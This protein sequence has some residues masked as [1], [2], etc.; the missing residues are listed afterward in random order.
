MPSSTTPRAACCVST[1]ARAKRRMAAPHCWSELFHW[2]G[3]ELFN[4]IDGLRAILSVAMGLGWTVMGG[5]GIYAN[6]RLF[7]ELSS[8]RPPSLP[9][10]EP[11]IVVDGMLPFLVNNTSCF[12]A[13]FP[14]SARLASNGGSARAAGWDSPLGLSLAH[15]AVAFP[16]LMR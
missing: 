16:W 10:F 2:G 14:L 9:R 15:S 1:V 12:V 13:K 6:R 11:T 3:S 8:D 4:C 7:R 5:I